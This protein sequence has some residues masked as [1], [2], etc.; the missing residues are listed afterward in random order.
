MAEKR[1][2][3]R[4]TS[5][6]LLKQL[7]TPCFVSAAS[8]H[9]GAAAK[10][11]SRQFRSTWD[12]GATI[13]MVSPRVVKELGLQT[14][15]Y[16]NIRHAGGEAG[17]VPIFQV[18]LLLYNNVQIQDVRVG[19]VEVRDID[20]SIGMDIINQGDFAVSN[21]NDATAFSFRI[22]SVEDFDFVKADEEY[23]R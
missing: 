6:G 9:Y 12:T 23:N 8:K 13:S 17:G 2:S 16:I 20:V 18:N 19:L 4:V 14:E 11:S 5:S 21:R 22:P 15:G 10:A 1:H 3:F 7:L